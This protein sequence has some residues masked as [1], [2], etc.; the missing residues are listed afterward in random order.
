MNS[1]LEI[2]ELLRWRLAR[3]EAE[4]P[5]PPGAARLL[6]L[7]RPWWEVWPERFARLR[8]RLARVPVAYGHAATEPRSGGR[9]HPLPA[10]V[11]GA[12]AT[13]ETTVRVLYLD[14]RRARLRLRFALETAIVP[15]PPT[16]EV[17]F[18]PE[19]R[20]EAP[21]SVPAALTMDREYR[22]DL[23]LS[24]EAASRWEAFKVTH[25]LP[26][27]LILRSGGAGG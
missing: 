7:A 10:L 8:Q 3:A 13:V 11:V 27:R 1:D 22:L 15:S 21:F 24:E 18:I 9:G 2:E 12:E 20:D 5:P 6:E 25:R 17:T 26:Y 19:G 4:A 16:F 23:E 14:V